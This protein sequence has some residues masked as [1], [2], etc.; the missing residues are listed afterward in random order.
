MHQ[1]DRIDNMQIQPLHS[2][3]I[4]IRKGVVVVGIGIGDAAAAWRN[5]V[6]CAGV[7]G[8]QKDGERSRLRHLL[9]IDQLIRLS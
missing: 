8:L 5:T 7:K 3:D 6:Q 9:Y 1:R 2:P 4:G